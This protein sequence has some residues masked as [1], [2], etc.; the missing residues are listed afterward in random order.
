MSQGETVTSCLSGWLSK[1]SRWVG[2]RLLSNDCFCP[3]PRCVRFCLRPVRVS[4]STDIEAELVVAKGEWG[5]QR[6]R[7]GVWELTDAN[8]PI[9]NR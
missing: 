3:G 9:L 6:D 4:V 7:L 1:I 2:P 8:Y 5:K